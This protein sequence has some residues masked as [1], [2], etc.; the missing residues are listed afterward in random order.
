LD[1]ASQS[2]EE[3]KRE[4]ESLKQEKQRVFGE[5]EDLRVMVGKLEEQ[6]AFSK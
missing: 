5:R 2:V 1:F 6:V 3:K 4:M